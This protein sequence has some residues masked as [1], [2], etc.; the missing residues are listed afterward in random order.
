M[1]GRG[2]G[3]AQGV[4]GHKKK[5]QDFLLFH[6]GVDVMISIFCDLYQ[7]SAKKLR[8]FSQNQIKSFKKL[9]E[10]LAKKRQYFRHFFWQ[11]I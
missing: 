3:E 6:S 4:A 10:V 5:N 9:A 1:E 8:F 2:G 11:N 7:L